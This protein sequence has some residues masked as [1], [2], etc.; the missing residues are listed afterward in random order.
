M[1]SSIWIDKRKSQEKVL[2]VHKHA[3]N[4][5]SVTH[6]I[7]AID[8]LHLNVKLHGR[9]REAPADMFWK[10]DQRGE[11]SSNA[12]LRVN[13]NFIHLDGP[14]VVSYGNQLGVVA[15]PA[16]ANWAWCGVLVA[17]KATLL[18]KKS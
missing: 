10:L 17:I 15:E 8:S 4:S 14:G 1:K 16:N 2:H 18:K 11:N 6:V 9:R 5:T 12:Y 3:C 13:E 7:S